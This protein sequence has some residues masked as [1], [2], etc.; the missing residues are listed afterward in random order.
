MITWADLIPLIARYGVEFAY[1]FWATVKDKSQ[2]TEEDW[3]SIIKLANTPMAEYI[4][5]A[6]IRAGLPP[7]I[8]PDIAP[9]PAPI[10]SPS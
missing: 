9:A 5:Q 7:D 8:P 2:P 6:R 3:Q 4:R 10:I 1:T